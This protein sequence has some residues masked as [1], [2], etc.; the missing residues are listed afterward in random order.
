[1][2][3]PFRGAVDPHDGTLFIN[4]VGSNLPG[5]CGS[6]VWEEV[7]LG[8]PGANYGW[9]DVEGPASTPAC[10]KAGVTYPIYTYSHADPDGGCAV[11]GGTFY[12]P[13]GEALLSNIFDGVYFFTDLCGGWIKYRTSAG[14]V[15][16]LVDGIDHPT[17]VE[18]GPDGALYYLA[19]FGGQVGRI[20]MPWSSFLRDTPTSGQADHYFTSGSHADQ[21]LFCDWDGNG[22]DTIGFHSGN[23]WFLHNA[24]DGSDLPTSFVFGDPSDVPVC[25]DWDGDGVATIGVRRGD[26]FYLRNSNSSGYADLVVQY[27]DASDTPIVGDWNGDGIDTVGVQRD[28]TFLLRDSNTS[29]FADTT[30]DFGDPGDAAVVGDWDGNGTDTIAVHRDNSIYFNDQNAAGYATSVAVYGD[31]GDIAVAGIW[32]ASGVDGI[33]VIR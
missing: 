16:K 30:F 33:G 11:T 7:N 15:V 8:A 32:T 18:T 17:A 14:D 23:Q 3:N 4:D 5:A 20:T 13:T 6:G 2:R 26:T 27:G 1:L 19:D 22:T 24:S 12:R 9:P 31:P 28:R 21:P 10:T 29:G 25:G